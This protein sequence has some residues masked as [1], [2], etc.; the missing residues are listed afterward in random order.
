[1]GR[2]ARSGEPAAHQRWRSENLCERDWNSEDLFP[3]ISDVN[4]R[5][6][7]RK[8]TSLQKHPKKLCV[9]ES[10][11]HKIVSQKKCQIEVEKN[12]RNNLYYYIRNS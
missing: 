10:A 1:M 4:D 5:F 11:Q 3:R 6:P 8:I 9:F 12:G 2:M 7:R